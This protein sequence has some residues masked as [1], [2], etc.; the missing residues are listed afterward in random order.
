MSGYEKA[1][2][3]LTRAL[4]SAG[5]AIHYGA[6]NVDLVPDAADDLL[7]VWTLLFRPTLLN[8]CKCKRV[9]TIFTSVLRSSA[10]LAAV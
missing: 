5:V 2:T 9:A 4:E 3:L 8:L 10:S 1:A 7:V 6:A